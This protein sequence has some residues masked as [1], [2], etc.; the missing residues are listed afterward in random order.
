M[1][2]HEQTWHFSLLLNV[3]VVVYRS[4]SRTPHRNGNM[5][6]S[7]W[8]FWT[9]SFYILIYFNLVL[10][11][12]FLTLYKMLK[13]I[14]LLYTLAG[15]LK[16][17]LQTVVNLTHVWNWKLPDRKCRPFH[18]SQSHCCGSQPVSQITAC[19]R[20]EASSMW[21]CVCETKAWTSTGKPLVLETLTPLRWRHSL[22]SN[23][24]VKTTQLRLYPKPE[25]CSFITNHFHEALSLH[26]SSQVT[27][28]YIAL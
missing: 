18:K 22:I 14:I 12:I 9:F 1:H 28:I 15:S 24:L 25:Y 7:T 10:F 23:P 5:F 2:L 21:T 4:V 17:F 19:Y 26:M 8:S 3:F 16:Y 6:L 20:A 11:W 13:H 27:F